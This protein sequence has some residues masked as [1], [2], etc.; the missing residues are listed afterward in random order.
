[1]SQAQSLVLAATAAG[2]L[3]LFVLAQRNP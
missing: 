2:F 3:I 1:M